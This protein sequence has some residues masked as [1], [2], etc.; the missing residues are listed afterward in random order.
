MTLP[1]PP[2]PPALLV[3]AWQTYLGYQTPAVERAWST[4]ER[5]KR[6]LVFLRGFYAGWT[7]CHA[8]LVVAVPHA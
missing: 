6:E 3:Q 1:T 4:T 8:H 7:A 2:I 5:R